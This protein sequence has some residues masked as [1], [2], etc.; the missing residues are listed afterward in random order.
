MASGRM[1]KRSNGSP[2]KKLTLYR[3]GK[4]TTFQISS[5]M[6]LSL[7]RRRYRNSIGS[8]CLPRVSTGLGKS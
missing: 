2:Q 1:G 7:A 4:S 6:T 8:F 3:M 5:S